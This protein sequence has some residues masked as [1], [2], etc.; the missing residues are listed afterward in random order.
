MQSRDGTGSILMGLDH[1]EH[2]GQLPHRDRTEEGE[3]TQAV[4]FLPAAADHRRSGDGNRGRSCHR[5]G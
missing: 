5:W 4:E 2:L 1:D 3:I